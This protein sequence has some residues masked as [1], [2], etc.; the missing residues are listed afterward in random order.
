MKT[1]AGQEKKKG[2]RRHMYFENRTML[3]G[4][5]E[6]EGLPEKLKKDMELIPELGQEGY[7]HKREQFY[8]MHADGL[9]DQFID[10]F[11]KDD[12]E[13]SS[14][15]MDAVRIAAKLCGESFAAE[16]FMHRA[17]TMKEVIG[18]IGD[19]LTKYRYEMLPELQE[20]LDILSQLQEDVVQMK[21][22][23]RKREV[24]SEEGGS[25]EDRGTAEKELRNRISELEKALQE[26]DAQLKTKDME[27]ASIK[28]ES[29]LKLSSLGAEYE[30]KIRYMK[31]AFK[32]EL[33]RQKTNDH[34][35]LEKERAMNMSPGGFFRRRSRKQEAESEPDN[36]GDREESVEMFLVKA[37][38]ENKYR[39]DQLDV[40][41][42][43]AGENLS[44]DE[45]RCLCRPELSAAGM[46]RLKSYFLKRKGETGYDF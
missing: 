41:T 8:L 46:E 45:I 38:S 31:L 3:T 26:K 24:L 34:L 33:E 28:T 39:E 11:R 23:L 30:A 40:I 16:T 37:F 5:K 17:F 19:G 22:F 6:P 25:E 18:K 2:D 14:A 21:T 15:T 36:Q 7:E 20:K 35:A 1:R 9:S 44:L 12:Q 27:I 29:G 42:A 43:A 4:W 10:Y 13:A 32:R